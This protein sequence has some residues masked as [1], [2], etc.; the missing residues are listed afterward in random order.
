MR[1]TLRNM[2]G[3]LNDILE[4]EDR[5]DLGKRIDE[6]DYA[7]QLLHRTQEVTRRVRLASPP[8]IGQGS[9]HDANTVAEYLDH[10]LPTGQ[11]QDFE[12][13]C[14][15]SDVYL[16]EVA[17][18]HYILTKVLSEPAH[19]DPALKTEF[20]RLIEDPS[21][22]IAHVHAA[23]AAETPT[24]GE[25]RKPEVPAYLREGRGSK[26]WLM[27]ATVLLA[28]MIAGGVLF[29]MGP[30]NS[31][32]PIAQL[33]VSEPAE[34][35]T[36][37]PDGPEATTPPDIELGDPADA[38]PPP[39]GAEEQAD[40]AEE[41]ELEQ[42]T[43]VTPGEEPPIE[44]T[45]PDD[46]PLEP[47]PPVDD[48]ADD[49]GDEDQAPDALPSD[50]LPSDALPSDTAPGE[51][52]PGLVL[53]DPPGDQIARVDPPGDATPPTEPPPVKPTPADND[54]V[55]APAPTVPVPIG[56]LLSTDEVLLR[57][58]AATDNYELLPGRAVL[59]T[60]DELLVLPTF[61]PMITVAGVTMEL[62]GG[63]RI[64]L[65]SLDENENPEVAV[66]YGRAILMTVGRADASI[67]LIL[68]DQSGVLRFGDADSR[69]AIEVRPWRPL[70]SD[71]RT[72]PASYA[73][74]LYAA[75]GDLRWEQLA[76]P[77]PL[78]AP[79]RQNLSPH[80]D[81]NAEQA[82]R[83]PAWIA[84]RQVSALDRRAMPVVEQ[85][86]RADANPRP[87]APPTDVRLRL[88]ELTNIRKTEVRSLA[89]RSCALIG[90]YTPLVKAF[91]DVDHKANW[92]VAGYALRDALLSDRRA[93]DE[94][95]AALE[96][97][98]PEH[99]ERLYRMLWGYSPS[100]L[101]D[102]GE[103]KT[104]VELL[105]HPELEFRV[106]AFWNL[107]D[108]TGMRLYY[109]PEA[110]QAERES[111]ILQWE[112]RLSSGEILPTHQR[113]AEP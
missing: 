79:H 24:N 20:Y 13:R 113:R 54:P 4:P 58:S 1:L 82:T 3:Y 71:P 63:T 104:L 33:F 34:P 91:D 72:T 10:V 67:K 66:L 81:D 49:H 42:P 44:P 60:G 97:F 87:G 28:A 100:G 59:N 110:R 6:S 50:A 5:S 93:A 102:R 74:D 17:S 9:S 94:V 51:E 68:G 62:D 11:V 37:A 56:R 96:R 86:L 8:V 27:A 73:V 69:A 31:E 38:T 16:G 83:I 109:Q 103:A 90:A 70:G 88:I 35:P 39:T 65:E 75:S 45:P 112:K 98:Y 29:A 18:C 26:V 36:D 107:H 77:L 7:K 108:I 40:P 15:E 52:A 64:K 53:P 105:N 22:P 55:A 78:R 25:R 46:A 80:P 57:Y 106:L 111:A 2:L 61:R 76:A 48:A 30:L 23:H 47:T 101:T 95:L 85:T 92:D 21:K 99:A 32:H 41:P 89:F 84:A 19:V 14:L 43:G 12:N